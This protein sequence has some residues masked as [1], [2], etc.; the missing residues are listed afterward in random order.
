MEVRRSR[1]VRSVRY[2]QYLNGGTFVVSTGM[3]Y[4]RAL[5]APHLIGNRDAACLKSYLLVRGGCCESNETL[6]KLASL[7]GF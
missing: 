2:L 5:A 3:V 4:K 7:A 1:A 6:L